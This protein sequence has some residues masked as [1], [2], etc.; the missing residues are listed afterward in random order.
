MHTL[1]PGDHVLSGDDVYGGTFR[2][3]DKVMRPMGI[4]FTFLDMSDPAAVRAAIRPSTK[5]IW[6]ETPTNPMLKIFDIAAMAE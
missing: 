6:M 4:D 1:K 2:L 5:M 3:F